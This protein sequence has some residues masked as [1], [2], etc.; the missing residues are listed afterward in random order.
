M[1]LIWERWVPWGQAR[2][3]ANARSA[4]TALARARAEREEVHRF[5]ARDLADRTVALQA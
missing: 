1:E 4:S 2:A 3:R 5:V